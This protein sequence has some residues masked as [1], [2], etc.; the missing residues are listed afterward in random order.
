MIDFNFF[1][2]GAKISKPTLLEVVSLLLI[3]AAIIGLAAI[4]SARWFSAVW[5]LVKPPLM[6]VAIA[7]QKWSW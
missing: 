2:V 3:L 6:V 5:G 7:T 1:R 4:G